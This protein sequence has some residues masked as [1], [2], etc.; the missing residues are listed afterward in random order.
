MRMPQFSC[1]GS[2]ENL[3]TSGPSERT[4]R[5]PDI[6]PAST[7]E[8]IS[9][10]VDEQPPRQAPHMK[11]LAQWPAWREPPPPAVKESLPTA[12]DDDKRLAGGEDQQPFYSSVQWTA[13]G[14]TILAG[15]SDNT[16]SSFV[17]PADLLQ[18]GDANR[19]LESQARTKL[20]EPTQAMAPAPYFSLADP[21]T[22]TYLVGCRDHP[23][24][25]YHA[26]P[27]P[28][29]RP[30]P[31]GTY[32]LIR[33]E[34][35]QYITPASLLWTYPG[36]HFLCGSSNRI[37]YFDVSR[38]GSDGPMLTVPTIPSKR[39]VSKGNGVG[40]RGTVAA[41]AASPPAADG[42]SMVAAGT[43]TRWMGL[44]DLGRT[45]RIVAN[46][47]IARAAEGEF[48]VDLVG[49]GIVQVV[50]S[51][52][53]RYLVINERNA[54]S[55]LVYDI[56][57]TGQLLAALCGRQSTTQQKLMCDVFQGDVSGDGRFEVWAGSQD[58]SVLVWEDVGARYGLAQ[59]LWDWHAH[60]SPVGGTALHSCG[61][62]VATCSGA[63]VHSPETPDDGAIPA[64]HP[65]R[66][67][68]RTLDESSLKIWSIGTQAA[69]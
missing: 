29:H 21:A 10:A 17:L 23:L 55:L 6:E 60:Q 67:T 28:G 2:V 33:K 47:S 18:S 13:D 24:H 68:T 15:A 46:W 35:E 50:W 22:Q 65:G 3:G 61:S 43:W 45:D 34:T 12:N 48:K 66:H 53:G 38:H 7:M 36:T 54:N 64:R 16:V 49:Q 57:S 62:V 37:D 44:Y 41:L 30:T 11:L 59:P 26:F 14:T 27:R 58:G 1:E 25:I 19:L 20:P 51:P 52:C 56:R 8:A 42:G 4:D 5:E 9:G 40:M 63:W 31:L 39:H 69:P 32:K